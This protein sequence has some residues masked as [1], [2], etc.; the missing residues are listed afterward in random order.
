MESA[1]VIPEYPR[2]APPEK[3]AWH[4]HVL[5]GVLGLLVMLVAIRVAGGE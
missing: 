2:P 4:G 3:L 1:G 5:A